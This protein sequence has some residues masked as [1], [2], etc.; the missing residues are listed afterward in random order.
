VNGEG[1][2]FLGETYKLHIT[3]IQFEPLRF[4]RGFYLSR[5]VLP[6]ARQV[7]IDWYKKQ[8]AEFI[9]ERA[10]WYA[11]KAGLTYNRVNI[12]DAR[13]RWGS[14]SRTGNLNF[15]WRLI[16]APLRVIDYVV[17]HEL[18]HLTVRN[19][20]GEFWN[21]VSVLLPDHEI[22]RAWLHKNSDILTL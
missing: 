21:R 5:S 15:S 11:K 8:A 9:E 16:M 12:T 6:Q 13:K 7:F 20:T 18:V 17:V 1:F 10:K 19:H 14:C 22:Q 3:D 2:M 4:D